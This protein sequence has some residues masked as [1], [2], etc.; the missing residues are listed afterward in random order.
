[1]G[2][3][4]D[5]SMNCRA[6]LV[7]PPRP[8]DCTVHCGDDPWLADGRAAPCVRKV[9]RDREYAASMAYWRRHA[10]L[11]AQMGLDNA[12]QGLEELARVRGK[13]T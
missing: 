9:V 3:Q 8:C 11:L 6:R 4:G 13:G 10:E 5:G 7:G 1:M 2:S 12:L